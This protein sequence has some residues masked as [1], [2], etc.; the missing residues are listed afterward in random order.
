MKI[1]KSVLITGLALIM[2]LT[3]TGG[4][5]AASNLTKISAYLNSNI[6][7]SVDGSKLSLKD[8][9]TQLTPIIYEGRTY[10]PAKML[11]EALDATVKWNAG[12]STVEVTSSNQDG[13][14]YND[15]SD[16]D[17]DSDSDDTTTPTTPST[18][19]GKSYYPGDTEPEKM[20]A[21]YKSVAKEG[22]TAYLNAIK[23]GNK[24]ALD[25]FIKKYYSYDE[26]ALYDLDEILENAHAKVD[27]ARE[28]NDAETINDVIP[29]ALSQVANGVFDDEYTEFQ[30][31]DSTIYLKYQYI[32]PESSDYVYTFYIEFKFYNNYYDPDQF[33]L[34]NI[35]FY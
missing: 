31:Y 29:E 5:Y 7:I 12:T 34:D 10:V 27:G 21:D 20:F 28:V 13:I 25:A 18:G 8:G 2:V 16:S 30:D 24:T 26:D 22:M 9:S 19:T 11:A 14:P 6:K 1:K 32:N 35:H 23:T 3:F 17:S 33:F 4:A 15:N